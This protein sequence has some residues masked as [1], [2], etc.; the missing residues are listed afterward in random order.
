M[1][2]IFLKKKL[3][4]YCAIQSQIRT[5]ISNEKA[6]INNSA[7]NKQISYFYKSL[8]CEKISFFKKHTNLF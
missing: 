5:I 7:I 3:E 6:I 2:K 4:K 1:E 8:Y